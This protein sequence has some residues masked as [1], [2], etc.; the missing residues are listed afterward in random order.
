MVRI[1]R[2]DE[3]G[4]SSAASYKNLRCGCNLRGLVND[5]DDQCDG[6]R[7]DGE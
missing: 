7:L 3:E 5:G 2:V 6:V 4:R 1:E